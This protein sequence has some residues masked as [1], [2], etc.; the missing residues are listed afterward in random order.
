MRQ[1]RFGLFELRLVGG[2]VDLRQ[3]RAFLDD[4]VVV[5]QLARI[6]GIAAK[7]QNQ[8]HDLAPTSTTSSGS[9]VPVALIV[10]R[11]SPRLIATV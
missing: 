9:A 11:R 1:G 4:G 7:F 5:D 6:V 3:H 8:T 2:G 10:E